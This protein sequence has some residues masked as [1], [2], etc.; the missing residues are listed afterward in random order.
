[1]KGACL[2][3][4][5]TYALTAS[6]ELRV[7]CHCSHCQ[8][9]TGSA[10]SV[11]YAIP[12]EHVRIDGSPGTYIDHG[13]SGKKVNRIF[14]RR[15]G[16]SVAADAEIAPHLIFMFGGTLEDISLLTPERQI[17]CESAQPWVHLEG[18][19]SYARLPAQSG[20]G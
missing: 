5:I 18:L 11:L 3:G 20:D 12:R 14:C 6:P 15:C 9:Q 4:D 17:F 16:S 1:M 10:F 19:E 7:V 8:K 2:C 13:D